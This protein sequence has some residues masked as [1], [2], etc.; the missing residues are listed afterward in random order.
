MNRFQKSLFVA[1]ALAAAVCLTTAVHADNAGKDQARS[2]D[3]DA[4]KGKVQS[5]SAEHN[6]FVLRDDK[7]REWAFQVAQ[8]AKIRINDKEGRLADLKEGDEVTVNSRRVARDVLASQGEQAGQVA[9]GRVERVSADGRQLT[10]KGHDGQERTFQ[11]GQDARVRVNDKEGQ[12]ADLKEGDHVAV[13]YAKNG[14]QLAARVILS[15]QRDQAAG[16]AVGQVQRVSAENNQ[17][18]VKDANGHEHTFQMGKDARVRIDEKE[19]QAS[20]LK[21]GNEVA[22]AYRRVASEITG[23]RA[24]K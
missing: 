5:I 22:V 19:G 14:D 3:Q 4:I 16:V 2:D 17:I 21:E 18:V 23:E 11:I 7:D 10:V 12:L 1:F 20:N 13:V 6:Q 24:N 8:D 9:G 15:A